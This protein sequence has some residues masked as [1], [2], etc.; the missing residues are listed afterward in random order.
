MLGRMQSLRFSKMANAWTGL[1][2]ANVSKTQHFSQSDRESVCKCVFKRMHRAEIL[3]VWRRRG[4]ITKEAPQLLGSWESG[5]H[6]KVACANA[7]KSIDNTKVTEIWIFVVKLRSSWTNRLNLHECRCSCSRSHAHNIHSHRL[8]KAQ[9]LKKLVLCI[10]AANAA[11]NHALIALPKPNLCLFQTRTEQIDV[12]NATFAWN[13]PKQLDCVRKPIPAET[14]TIRRSW[15][16]NFS[17]PF[18]SY[19]LKCQF[20]WGETRAQNY[21]L[22]WCNV[23][24][25][26][27]LS[28][29]TQVVLKSS[30][31]KRTKK[32][33]FSVE[34]FL[35]FH[36]VLA[37][38]T[39]C[40]SD[41]HSI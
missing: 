12:S 10:F 17:T 1:Y 9:L 2:E 34:N 37:Q 25:W 14:K 24:K 19:P 39:C 18:P 22:H 20:Q 26:I 40:H 3:F 33:F 15:S 29:K 36:F 4:Q 35:L 28:G 7:Q 13:E 8:H 5:F 38:S 30:R 23:R 11:R 16:E 41:F 27:T 31:I 21:F 32:E 6:A